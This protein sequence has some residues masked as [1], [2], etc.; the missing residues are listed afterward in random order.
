MELV[1]GSNLTALLMAIALKKYDRNKNVALANFGPKFGGNSQSF[2][3]KNQSIDLGMQTFYECGVVWADKLVKE[4]LTAANIEFNE[5]EWPYHDPCLTWQHGRL[6]NSVYPVHQ[7]AMTVE[8]YEQVFNKLPAH[9]PI[10]DELREIIAC[11]FGEDIWNNVFRPI[12]KKFTIGNLSDL[13]IVSLA[14]LPIDRI[15]APQVSDQELIGKPG[16]LSKLAF[17]SSDSIPQENYKHR[18]TIYPKRG[19]IANLVSALKA[20]AVKYGVKIHND[21]TWDDLQVYD[22]QLGVMD[23]KPEKVFWTLPNKQ[24]NKLTGNNTST[25]SAS[26]FAGCHVAAFCKTGF[27]VN[28]AHYLLSFDDD[29]IFRITFYGSLAGKHA[30][31]YASI[32]LLFAPEE[33]NESHLIEFLK[34]T[35]IIDKDAECEFSTPT[36]SPWPISFKKGYIRERKNEEKLLQ[37]K[38][39]NLVLLNSNP[40]KSSIMQTPTLSNR[41]SMF[42]FI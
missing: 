7:S 22:N 15:F 32:E 29:P 24:L 12:A 8:E 37:E 2:K 38:I 27:K 1:V 3:F 42:K 41:L 33:F 21:L 26:P 6:Y 10:S 34:K 9:N 14:P 39:I 25:S 31:A 18:S 4:A 28:Q 35:G 20:L 13:S 23:F 11:D 36:F 16:L 19:G 17:S 40:A 30:D 5:F